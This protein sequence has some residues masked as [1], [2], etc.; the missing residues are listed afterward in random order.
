MIGSFTRLRKEREVM[1]DFV[2]FFRVISFCVGLLI[3]VILLILAIFYPIGKYEVSRFNELNGTKYTMSDWYFA[4]D[5]V[6]QFDRG[7]KV[8]IE[9]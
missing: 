3:L 6:T 5:T 7:I 1:D 2:D 8:R 4:W 9:N